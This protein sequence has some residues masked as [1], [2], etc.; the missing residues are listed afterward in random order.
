MFDFC[1]DISIILTFYMYMY[2]IKILPR[3]PADVS[4]SEKHVCSLLL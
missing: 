1:S 4:V 3:G 2:L